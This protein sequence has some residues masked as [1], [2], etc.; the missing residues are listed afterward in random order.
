MRAPSLRHT[1]TFTLAVSIA[2][3]TRSRQGYA[4]AG[5]GDPL[6]LRRSLRPVSPRSEERASTPS[7]PYLRSRRELAAARPRR[8]R[9][10]RTLR[11]AARHAHG[12]TRDVRAYAVVNDYGRTQPGRGGR[13]YGDERSPLA[14]LERS[15]PRVPVTTT[16]ELSESCAMPSPRRRDA[17]W[18][19][20]KTNLPSHPESQVNRETRRVCR[21]RS[22]TRSI[23]AAEGPRRGVGVSRGRGSRR[24]KA[25]SSRTRDSVDVSGPPRVPCQCGARACVKL[26]WRGGRTPSEAE[27]A[28]NARAQSARPS[29]R[30]NESRKAQVR[31]DDHASLT[32]RRPAT[33]TRSRSRFTRLV[34][35]VD[36]TPRP[37]RK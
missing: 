22:T 20:R 31:H 28:R 7:L 1:R 27:L 19:S 23:Y 26:V 35:I 21:E 10:S 6:M 16:I 11:G 32:R 30:R 33:A 8:T 25:G 24:R 14:S 36:G 17:A 2:P 12:S 18:T 4:L 13:R 3:T 5:F 37:S 9:V 15:W 34:R 29:R